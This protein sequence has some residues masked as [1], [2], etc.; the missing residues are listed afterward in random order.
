MYSYVRMHIHLQLVSQQC[1]RTQSV[2]TM[3]CFR[4]MLALTF[5][6][7]YFNVF[8]DKGVKSGEHLMP[9]SLPI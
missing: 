2:F 1:V 5:L 4:Y 8:Q 3:D 6:H 9:S 7:S